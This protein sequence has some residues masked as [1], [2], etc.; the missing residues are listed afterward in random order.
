VS[1]AA[2]ALALGLVLSAVGLPGARADALC[3]DAEVFSGKILTDVCWGCLFPIRIAGLPIGAGTV[4]SGAA[5]DVL[6]LLWRW[7]DCCV[8]F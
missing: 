8:T 4:P 5:E 2:R 1:R 6:Y 7:T 3:P